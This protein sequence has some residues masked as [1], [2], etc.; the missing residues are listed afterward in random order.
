[1]GGGVGLV[2]NWNIVIDCKL[3]ETPKMPLVSIFDLN[4]P[5]KKDN[6]FNEN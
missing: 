2:R 1:M 6:I 4:M 3:P 5:I